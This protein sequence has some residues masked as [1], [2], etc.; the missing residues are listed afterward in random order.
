MFFN[1]IFCILKMNC[2]VFRLIKIKIL[3]FIHFYALLRSGLTRCEKLQFI[4]IIKRIF[5][6]IRSNFVPRGTPAVIVSQFEV[7]LRCMT[8]H[9]SVGIALAIS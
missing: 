9:D 4:T 5:N 3:K 1:T 2:N 6:R 7:N 8:S